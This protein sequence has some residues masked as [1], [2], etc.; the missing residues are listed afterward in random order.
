MLLYSR[1]PYKATPVCYMDVS[2]GTQ[3]PREQRTN[4]QEAQIKGKYIIYIETKTGQ[5]AC[6]IFKWSS[7]DI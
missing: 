3:K 2:L 1:V 6:L 7:E 5:D 4:W